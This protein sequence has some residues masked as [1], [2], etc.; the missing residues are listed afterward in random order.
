MILRKIDLN[1]SS[2]ESIMFLNYISDDLIKLILITAE[3]TFI[4]YHKHLCHNFALYG[5]NRTAVAKEFKM[6]NLN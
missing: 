5:V 4:Y 1:A 2:R 6:Q 3:I